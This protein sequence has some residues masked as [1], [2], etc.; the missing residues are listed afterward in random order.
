MLDSAIKDQLRVIF[1][2]L[3]YSYTLSVT[4]DSSSDASAELLSMLEGIAECSD[5]ISVQKAEGDSI[6]LVIL[7]DGESSGIS[8]RAV[9]GGHEF[10]SLLLAILNLDGKGKNLP[11]EFT[12]RRIK[13]LN[14]HIE[15]T[16]YM[17]LS[18]TNCP[19][20]VQTLN[21]FA[22]YGKNI[23]HV[24]V[25]GALYEDEVKSLNIQSVPTVYADGEMLHVGRGSMGELLDKLEAKYG[26]SESMVGEHKEYDVIVA[27]GGPAG[28]T[29][30][31]YSARKGLKVAVV[32][33]RIGGQVNETTSI[34]NIP[35][36]P[37]TMGVQL[38]ADLKNHMQQ[39]S[40]DILENRKI[41]SVKV[42]DG[43]KHLTVKGGDSYSSPALIISTGAAWRQ[44]GVEGESEYIGRGVAFCPHCDGPFYKDRV[45]AVIGGGNSGVEAA[46]D[47]AGI[48][49][50]VI[51]FEF[52]E[53]LKADIVLQD[54]LRSLSNVEI[55]TNRQTI[56]V[57][58]DGSKV[59]SM[60]VRDRA[61]E[62]DTTI[63]LDGIFVQIG[64]SANSSPFA[65]LVETNRIGEI[66]VDRNGRT[67]VNG[68]YAAGDVTDVSYKQIVISMGEGAKAALAAFDDRIRDSLR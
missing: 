48:C 57:V 29:A 1:S 33:E 58:G 9:P 17:S 54:K 45:V 56:K 7:K 19:D 15:L 20:I 32:A 66:I 38:A 63:T 61:T 43:V 55:F 22:I 42:E 41:E 67:S 24:A 34:E 68:I 28:A 39:Y 13:S 2:E 50:K 25:D 23:S 37:L 31:I 53:T 46:I 51:V 6:G 60:V 59:T 11:D 14:A 47:L 64:L 21:L 8:F 49:S 5:R 65:E 27:G 4:M 3:I 36:V 52:M 10:N 40:I 18:C 35:S 62:Q 26:T 44:L 16:T 30:A 12:Q